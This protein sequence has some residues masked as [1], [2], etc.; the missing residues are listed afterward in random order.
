MTLTVKVAEAKARLSE[1]LA[2]VEAGEEV[3]IS[4]GPD[5]IARLSPLRRD[6]DV[7][8][9]IAEIRAARNSFALAPIA[10]EEI[11]EWKAEGRR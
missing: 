2:K 1:L 11:L 9:V 7:A 10:L 6:N 4:R 3:I 8:A 5:P